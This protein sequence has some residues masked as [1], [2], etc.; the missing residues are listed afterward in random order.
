MGLYTSLTVQQVLCA[1]N[2]FI[3]I[4]VH[5]RTSKLKVSDDIKYICTPQYFRV[6]MTVRPTF[7]VE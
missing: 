5:V 1:E 2:A 6:R 4:H 3:L 7:T